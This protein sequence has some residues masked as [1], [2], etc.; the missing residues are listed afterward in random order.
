[1]IRSA[2]ETIFGDIFTAPNI[3]R[4]AKVAAK[5]QSNDIITNVD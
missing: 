1:V 3:D 4:L 2:Y 5:S